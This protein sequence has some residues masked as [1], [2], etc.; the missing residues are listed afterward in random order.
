[1]Y[2]LCYTSTPRPVAACI[3]LPAGG[4]NLNLHNLKMVLSKLQLVW[5]I[6]FLDDKFCTFLRSSVSRKTLYWLR[7]LRLFLFFFILFPFVTHTVRLHTLLISEGFLLKL[8]GLNDFTKHYLKHSINYK[9]PLLL[10]IYSPLNIFK[11]LLFPDKGSDA[12]IT[13]NENPTNMNNRA[14][15]V[16]HIGFCFWTSFFI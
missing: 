2:S 15:V 11:G 4:T 14:I 3:I 9:I 5:L 12:M 1:M 8:S 6:Y 7:W 10:T 13:G 16:V